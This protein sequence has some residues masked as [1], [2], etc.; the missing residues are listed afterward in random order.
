MTG[1]EVYGQGPILR[2][3]PAEQRLSHVL[4][5]AYRHRCGPRG[6]NARTISAILPE[7]AREIRSAGDGA[8]GLRE[9]AWALV[10]LPGEG[11][12]GF[13]DALLI[14]RS[15]ANGKRAYYL[16]HAPVGT[17]PHW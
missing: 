8:H 3:W 11:D 17:S 4:A 2:G 5:I 16:T 7:H 9:Y 12:D 10:P 14:R 15:R 1:D 6:Q 13:D